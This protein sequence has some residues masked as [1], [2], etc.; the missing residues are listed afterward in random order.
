MM[1]RRAASWGLVLVGCVPSFEDRPWRVDEA[2]IVAIAAEPAE[3]RPGEGVG[4]SALVIEPDGVAADIP[5]WSLC[6]QPRTAAERTSV[7]EACATGEGVLGV[8]NPVAIPT[9]SC[10]RFGPN[11]PPT[12]GGAPPQ[13]PAD[14]DASGGYF[15]PARADV[16]SVGVPAF[17][18]VR[19]RCDL[20][21]ATRA[22]FDDYE[23][24]Y[25]LNVNPAVEA[26]QIDGETVTESPLQATSGASIEWT[27]RPALG[28]AEP[29]VFYDEAGGRLE[30][31]V[32]A[33]TVRWY[34]TDGVLTR[35]EQTI[36]GQPSQ[37][38]SE[39][40]SVDWTLPDSPGRVH[41][42]AVVSDERG[43]VSW[44]AVVVD[45]G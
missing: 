19:L 17:G 35:G 37:S 33:L 16:P 3:A 30:D 23:R 2:R 27:V 31:R 9:D 18:F 26:V 21:G 1:S 20:S 38:E 4:L 11:P 25:S 7:S 15:L 36:E 6:M 43:G 45:V 39:A 41:G 32:E 24:R 34:V 5:A 28:A 10:A 13:R 8:T 44:A 14:P 40:L 42:W 29:Y 22:I 12:E